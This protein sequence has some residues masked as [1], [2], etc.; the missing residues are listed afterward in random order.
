MHLDAGVDPFEALRVVDFG[1]AAV[2]PA[3]PVASHAAIERIVG[4]VVDAGAIPLVLGG[5]T[6]S[7]SRTSAPVPSATARSG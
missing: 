1:D 6:R 5:T 4:D 2:I 7:P 3:D